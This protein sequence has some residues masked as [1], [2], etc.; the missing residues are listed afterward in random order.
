MRVLII[1]DERLAA[2]RLVELITRYSDAFD[3]AGP[4]DSVEGAVHWFG[5]HD[6]PDLIFLDIHLADGNSFDIFK[7]VQVNSAIIFTTA[8]DQYAIEAFKVNS[9]DYLLKPIDYEDLE[10]GLKKF[11]THFQ[12][13]DNQ[14]SS[15][16]VNELIKSFGKKYKTRFVSKVGEHLH[17][18][19]VDQI[20]YFYS[21]GKT[22]YLQSDNGRRHIVDFPL[23]KVESMVDPQKFFRINRKYIVSFN[24]IR[25]ML[26]HSNSRL[27]LVLNN[28]DDGDVIVSR[29][30]VQ[31]FKNWLDG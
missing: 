12:K 31:D 15:N 13:A 21:E 5:E 22:T 8:Y 6:H 3:I 2:D 24:S 4:I 23:D 16:Q 17:A 1:E 20:A 10:R 27:R 25:D 30:R 19:T 14:L 7:K 9:I 29:E 11:E 26:S 18:I 28:C